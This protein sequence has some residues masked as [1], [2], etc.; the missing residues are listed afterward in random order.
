[1]SRIIKGSPETTFKVLLP[2]S[3]VLLKSILTHNTLCADV[4]RRD[5]GRV[6]GHS[7]KVSHRK[8]DPGKLAINHLSIRSTPDA[9]QVY[10]IG[11]S[12]ATVAGAA[13]DF[14]QDKSLG[15]GKRRRLG[16]LTTPLYQNRYPYS[17]I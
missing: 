6:V 15:N 14:E 16:A 9:E 1:M 2:L 17:E 4:V 5:S 11:S 7:Y 8:S 3:K 12:P 13:F 10:M